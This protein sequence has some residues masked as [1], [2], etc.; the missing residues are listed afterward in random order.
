MMIKEDYFT[1]LLGL[2]NGM[3]S[4]DCLSYLFSR[5]DFQKFMEVFIDWVK[6]I[7]KIKS[8]GK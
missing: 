6:E 4:H 8:G 5:I 7:V 3:T 1:N 2:E